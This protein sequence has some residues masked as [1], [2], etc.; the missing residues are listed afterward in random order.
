MAVATGNGGAASPL[1]SVVICTYNRSRSLGETLEALSA[2]HADGFDYEVVVVDNNSSD[3]TRAVVDAA[4]G[5][6]GG[7]LRYVFEPR[8]GKPYALNTGVAAARGDVLAL[9]DDDVKPDP[10]WLSRLAGTMQACRADCVY[11]KILPRWMGDRPAWLSAWFLPQLALL[12]YGEEAFLATSDKHLF[13][14]ANVALTKAALA[15]VGP[16]NVRLG[17]RGT[18][19]GGEEDTDLFNRLLTAGRRIAYA[20]DAVVYHAVPAERLR[21]GYFRQWHFDHGAA[22]AHVTPCERGRGLFGI[23]FWSVREGLV[24]L[25][26]YLMGLCTGDAEGRLRHGMKLLCDL[27]FFTEKLKIAAGGARP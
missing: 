27:G 5:R 26:G 2:Q 7:R 17:N 1:V 20:P 21:L 3:D 4:Q 22:L 10:R 24:H 25:R 23:P 18:R 6:F 14:G 13:Y 11:G 9:T 12:D 16:F 15:E 8:Q 19:M